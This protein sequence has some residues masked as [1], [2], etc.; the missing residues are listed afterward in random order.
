MSFADTLDFAVKIVTPTIFLIGLK[1]LDKEVTSDK[2]FLY[3]NNRLTTF[4]IC[5]FASVL[6]Y[7]VAMNGYQTE[8]SIKAR[9]CEVEKV[10]PTHFGELK[11]E[12]CAK[13][14]S[15]NLYQA[16]LAKKTSDENGIPVVQLGSDGNPA[17]I[18]K[19][20]K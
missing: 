1:T 19:D 4:L 8:V 6:S 12:E 17:S 14:F 11:K 7:M 9:I 10:T 5:I 20:V 3:I 13:I 16:T 15:T 2:G 18:A